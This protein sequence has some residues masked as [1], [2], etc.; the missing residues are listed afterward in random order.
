M[1]EPRMG[2]LSILSTTVRCFTFVVAIMPMT[3]VRTSTSAAPDP[4]SLRIAPAFVTEKGPHHRTWSRVTEEV[5]R[6]GRVLSSTNTAYV[7]LRNGMHY[8]EGSQWNE[9]RT[10]I[11]RAD[12]F[13]IARYG[14]HKV[15]VRHQILIVV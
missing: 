9:S 14:P 10:E 2:T 13:A 8:W 5:Q 7:E 1:N 6:N 3:L 4:R 15:R 11:Q 12:G